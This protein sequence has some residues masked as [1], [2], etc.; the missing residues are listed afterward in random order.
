MILPCT[1]PPDAIHA[2]MK[3][4]GGEHD[5][6]AKL[7]HWS[8]QHWAPQTVLAVETERWPMWL[9][10]AG[11]QERTAKPGLPGLCRPGQG[12]ELSQ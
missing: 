12:K 2:N 6:T 8:G 1:S 11:H 10:P 3:S 4:V 5:V 9:D 7:N